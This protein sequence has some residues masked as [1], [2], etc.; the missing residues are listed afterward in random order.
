MADEVL[1]RLAATAA[2]LVLSALAGAALAVAL[3]TRPL[4]GLALAASLIAAPLL[5]LRPPLAI[6]LGAL[7]IL[8][9]E[10]FPAGLGEVSERSL[11]TAFYAT[12]LG[13]PGF[14][15]PDLILLGGTA[16]H[17]AHALVTRQP[18]ALPRDRVAAGLAAMATIAALSVLVSF[19]VED[20]LSFGVIQ[21]PG[22]IGYE[23]NERSARLI[24]LFQFKNYTYLFFAWILGVLHLR[25]RASVTALLKTVAFAAALWALTGA[26]RLILHPQWIAQG[27]P[28][29]YDSPSVWLFAMFGFYCVAAWA[30]GLATPRAG[31]AMFL[32]SAVFALFILASFRRTMWGGIAAC[33]PVLLALLPGPARRRLLMLACAT[34]IPLGLTLA[35]TP[36]GNAVLASVVER[37]GQTNSEDPSTLYRLA[38]FK[39]MSDNF[40]NL[41][42][43]GFGARPLWNEFV[44]LG[45]FRTHMENV[46]SLYY[47]LLLRTGWIGA[48]IAL[49]AF[50]AMAWSAFRLAR[51]AVDARARVLGVVLALAIVMYLFSGLFNPVCLE[52]R[53][54][55][56]MGLGLA[57]LSR[58]AQFDRAAARGAEPARA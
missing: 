52:A 45:E 19:I 44:N 6:W 53:Y 55:I 3:D 54:T 37:L 46:H 39:Y 58:L 56:L 30:H 31:W 43:L 38:T 16:L 8:V 35:F 34:A 47:W 48:T 28:V 12:S 25:D 4:L 23:S 9:I 20:P 29:F 51:R 49:G 21:E 1:G 2:L 18:L 17:L 42:W 13:L 33:L 14:Y 27:I 41:P 5:A 32:L 50:A 10:E 11:R 22:G 57:L 24:A 15:A 26:A 40:A 36:V 7:A